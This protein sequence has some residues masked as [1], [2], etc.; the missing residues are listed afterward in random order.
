MR[1]DYS[2][3]G[4]VLC[5][6]KPE[7]Y[8]N[9]KKKYNQKLLNLFFDHLDFSVKNIFYNFAKKESS[10]PDYIFVKELTV[11][12]SIVKYLKEN[13]EFSNGQIAEAINR[14]TR[15]IWHIYNSATKKFKERFVE[16]TIRFSIPLQIFSNKNLSILENL[17][18]YLKEQKGMG[19]HEIAL[20]I[21]RDDRTVWTVY[22][23]AVK[24]QNK[25][26][27]KYKY[28]LNEVETLEYSKEYSKKDYL[29]SILKKEYNKE[30]AISFI[31][32]LNNNLE[33]L[34]LEFLKE[35]VVIPDF[36]FNKN[37]TVLES[38]VKYLK[39]NLNFSYSEI[40]DLTKRDERNI[41]H[42][43]YAANKKIKEKFSHKESRF[44]IPIDILS[45]RKLS[46]LENLVFYLRSEF[47]LSYHEIAMVIS[48]DDRTVWTVYQKAK[49]K[50]E[51]R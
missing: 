6:I 17:V 12:E 38:V 50:Y 5:S 8:Q 9:I 36:V 16:T 7:V 31:N 41:W 28:N 14:D 21:K 34:F 24:K 47:N 1:V 29:F 33:I 18:F 35:N 13:L 19:Y 46:I 25:N 27:G 26:G 30:I 48:R 39:E 3:K 40:G 10:L 37:A 23:K 2:K 45:N 22:Q 42:T 20:E 32:Y 11:L 4:V 49:R 15:N 44:S 51:T 43:Y